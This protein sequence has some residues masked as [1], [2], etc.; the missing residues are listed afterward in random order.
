M[1]TS[2]ERGTHVRRQ[3][4]GKATRGWIACS[5]TF[6]V[7]AAGGID[8]HVALQARALA[9]TALVIG[10]DDRGAAGMSGARRE[11]EHNATGAH[12]RRAQGSSRSPC[13]SSRH[14]C[15]P[16]RAALPAVEWMAVAG[17]VGSYR[18]A[19]TSVREPRPAL[20]LHHL[21]ECG[22]ERSETA[23]CVANTWPR[24]RSAASAGPAAQGRGE[25]GRYELRAGSRPAGKCPSAECVRRSAAGDGRGDRCGV[26][27]RACS[28][29]AATTTRQMWV[30]GTEARGGAPR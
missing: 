5:H 19:L 2:Y 11:C 9:D 15:D 23:L 10:V 4:S 24:P 7:S 8:G 16:W 6:F 14:D 26:V 25:V 21:Q 30:T 29:L 18:E 20:A 28:A 27:G 3:A 22:S 1:E 12:E 13:R 17:D